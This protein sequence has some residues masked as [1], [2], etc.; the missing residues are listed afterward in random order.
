MA[1][2][3]ANIGVSIDTS[4]ALSQLKNL[5]RQIS[6][7]HTSV[8]K[9]SAT[10]A[11]AQK[12]LQ[13]NFVNSINSIGAFS[14][15]LR[16]VRS[17]TETFT[18][19]LE[20]NKFSMGEYFRFSA[21][22]TKTFGRKFATEMGIIE[23]TAVERVKTL[24]TQYVKL[25]RDASGAMQSI[26]IR[27]N[28]L[29]LQDLGTQAQIAAQKQ[30][31]FN[32]LVKQGSTN[33]LNFG[34][35]TQWAGRQL[36]VGFTLP[37]ITL[38]TVA[39]KTFMDME[40]Q[41][42]KFR[43]VYGDLFTPDAER[44]KA[45][46]EIQDL[47][48]AFTQYGVAASDVVGVA[49]DAA[50]AGFAGVDLQ[51]QTEQSIRLSILG[52]VDYQKALETT[53]SL[54]NAFQL[55]SDDLA[56][57]INF[58]NAVE[59]QTVV[60]LDDITT[61]IPKVAPVIQSLGG[62][63][64]DL[65]FFLAAMKEGGVNA[66]EGANA[67]KS[68]LASLINPTEKSAE[69]LSKMGINIRAIVD[70]NQGDLRGT[71]IGFATALDQLDPL[72]RARAIEQLFG[73]FQFAR[74]STLFDNVIREGNQASRVIDLATASVEELAGMAESELGMSAQSAMN[75]FLKVVEDLKVALVPIGE[76]FLQTVT[77][78]VEVIGDIVAKFNDLPNDVKKA[79]TLVVTLV[80]GL[81]PVVL[82]TFG[83]LANGIANSIKFLALLRNGFLRLTGQTQILGNSTEYMT[84]EQLEAAAAAM[85]LDQAHAKLTQRFTAEASAVMKL[86]DAY[87]AALRSSIK[88]A[89]AN[90]RAMMPGF[91]APQGFA[92]GGM[93]GGSGNKDT[94]PAMLTPGEFVV[95]K[96][97]ASVAMP[98]LK[99]L[100]EGKLPGFNE[101][102][103][104]GRK[105]SVGGRGF[106]AASTASA[107]A[108]QAFAER[109]ISA[110]NKVDRVIDLLDMAQS[111]M[112]KITSKQVQELARKE[113]LSSRQKPSGIQ[114]MHLQEDLGILPSGERVMGSLVRGGTI[115]QNQQLRSGQSTEAFE[116][117]WNKVKD[118]LVATLRDGGLDITQEVKEMAQ[119]IDDEIRD[120]AIKI[121]KAS[122]RGLVDDKILAQAAK[123]VIDKNAAAGGTRGA[124]AG[125][126]LQQ[127][128]QRVIAPA[129]KS[130]LVAS[131]QLQEDQ[132][133]TDWVKRNVAAGLAVLKKGTGE[134]QKEIDGKMRTIAR[135]Q[136]EETRQLLSEMNELEA[137]TALV[138]GKI[139]DERIRLT[140]GERR[141]DSP[142]AYVKSS[143]K[144]SRL[145]G[146][147]A[148]KAFNDGAK[149]ELKKAD[150]AYVEKRKRK[151]PHP[152]AAKDGIDDAKSYDKA[153]E[154]QI[155]QT[156]SKPR[157]ASSGGVVKFDEKSG[158]YMK[159][160]KF[161]KQEA[162]REEARARIAR[163]NGAAFEDLLGKT[164]K[165]SFGLSAAAGALSMFG[166]P[167]GEAAGIMFQLSSALFGL[168]TVTE[169]LSRTKLAAARAE[170]VRTKMGV[171]SGASLFTGGKGIGGLF[172]NIGTGLKFALRFLGPVGIGLSALAVGIPFIVNIMNEQ[173]A[174]IEGL[175][176]AARFTSSQLEFLAER[177]GVELNR[178]SLE[179]AF[180]PSAEGAT[181]S[182]VNEAAKFS[183]DENFL[184][185]FKVPIE[186]IQNVSNE[187]AKTLLEALNIQ[188]QAAGFGPE[189]VQTIL[190]GIAE[191]ANKTDIN[192]E[193]TKVKIDF[194]T[195]EGMSSIR[196]SAQAAMDN[197]ISALSSGEGTPEAFANLSTTFASLFE[198][199]NL[200]LTSGQ[201][202][203]AD[204]NEQMSFLMSILERVGGSGVTEKLAEALNISE[205]LEGVKSYKD[206]LLLIEAAVAGVPDL[207][208][209]TEAFNIL[210]DNDAS[211]E[212]RKQ[213]L[214]DVEDLKI[215]VK[216]AALETQNLT[217]ANEKDAQQI[218][219]NTELQN[220]LNA[221]REGIAKNVEDINNAIA[222]FDILMEAGWSAE[223][224]YSAASNG[225]LAFSI[226][227]SAVDAA[228][229]GI[230]LEQAIA[231]AQEFIKA[232][233]AFED[234]NPSRSG[235]GGGSA[236]KS[237]FQEAIESLKEQ[238]KEIQ[239]TNTA[240][241]KLR[242]TGFSVAAAFAAAKDPIL[243]AAIASTQVGTAKWRELVNLIRQVNS[244][245]IQS[246]D[247]Q[248]AAF[249]D[250]KDR[251]GEY[252]SILRSEVNL[253]YDRT[254]QSQT[255]SI[256]GL[257]S[258]IEAVN[259][260]IAAYQDQISDIQRS[261]EIEFGRPIAAL[262]EESS[263]LSNDLTLIDKAAEEITKRYE[264]QSEALE[265]VRKVNERILN[266][267]KQ[268]QG[269]AAALS[270]GDV[271][272]AA[273]MIQDMRA[274]NA[275][276]AA[277]SQSDMLNAARD[278]ELG[279]LRS[280]SGMTREQILER[281][282]DIGQQIFELEEKKEEKLKAI[283]GLE[284]KI[285]DIQRNRLR[286][287]QAA[288]D[289]ANA[290]LAA[291]EQQRDTEL[292]AI[293]EKERA[294]EEAQ[295][296]L[297]LARIESGEFNDI[298]EMTNGLLEL[299]VGE[300]EDFA[301]YWQALRDKTITL[302][303]RTV[304]ESV[305]GAGTG[306]TGG[307]SDSS[308][309]SSSSS[310]T[311][312]TP[313]PV[314]PPVG[315]PGTGG[316][317]GGGGGGPALRF[318]AS[319]GMVKKYA[320]GGVASS[321]GSDTVPSML[322]PGE[323]V[324][325]RS[326]SRRFGPLLDAI[327]SSRGGMF[328]SL[329]DKARSASRNGFA[330]KS[331]NQS[332]YKLPE[333]SYP[334]PQNA[335][336]IYSSS[337]R[338]QGETGPAQIDNSVY[339]Y[340]L[341]VNVDGGNL[342]A[343]QVANEVINK[344]KRVDSQRLRN[345]VIR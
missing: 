226:A 278:A 169:L 129:T 167:V 89:A 231:D 86:R 298:I 329:G 35:N 306:G 176:N 288:L 157:R 318:M 241:A 252:F 161:L 5:Q 188:L 9:S 49:A 303:V 120:A 212:A 284:D 94:V 253:R 233:K 285:Y 219:A 136:G 336:P 283:Q 239:N 15:E 3:N 57:S 133:W 294:W 322:T 44:Q 179:S 221:A 171:A 324:I 111:N 315:T 262:Q 121:A 65:A 225:A 55:S 108:I 61:A 202:S 310:Q 308:S 345:Q 87:E 141:P 160:D 264:E 195:P 254:I 123:G 96:E 82:M 128:Q 70:T 266:Q 229:A 186:S 97:S 245:S 205:E 24:Q 313:T 282:F 213:A 74:I 1:D 115:T 204:F 217:A 145:E 274:A 109:L 180:T 263:D 208:K 132:T 332:V 198:A 246:F 243:A 331:F 47:A 172:K 343:N 340:N 88:F 224:A 13:T 300:I 203:A 105:V 18:N 31:I 256:N 90:P 62:D 52:Q 327:N 227:L 51:R 191:A 6:Q 71:V 325:N 199:L 267:Q 255:A 319:G 235:G 150:D 81:G 156:R 140:I 106:D 289:T 183:E 328:G 151:S 119:E 175:G 40:T 69:M 287:L 277:V 251:A 2:V 286:P 117:E 295:L 43:K 268:Q 265:Q 234:L 78:F 39:T 222:A 27:P 210:A 194:G 317:G 127:S 102:G 206:Q 177:F 135:V 292:A 28:I 269:L 326:S 20:K 66:S 34:K 273:S 168:V 247:G 197:V 164:Q 341:S 158:Q 290:A 192:L 258:S 67:L 10:A 17:T 182:Q 311:E 181:Q 21:A 301:A 33:L 45:L 72:N 25:G 280:A 134:I 193:F 85:S 41:V 190:M 113:G 211:Q 259:K 48:Q 146:E 73:K 11:A 291:T 83:L 144:D 185:Q 149:K 344:L 126:L 165:L 334:A 249:S 320:S 112:D 237:P 242:D 260:E 138:S 46:E 236:T 248:R 139:G 276:A 26:A 8:A 104:V 60:S 214:E 244:M 84:N 93:V 16:T 64:K 304:T 50:A 19:S 142:R 137:R 116:S 271:S 42:I 163:I 32:Q 335:G 216:S 118:G 200:G 174:K 101:G 201:I 124:V 125:T 76:V 154:Q 296:A 92:S 153:F 337:I 100:N 122:E 275:Q 7:F 333:R 75:R 130:S 170:A 279:G 339:N 38:G 272:A 95:N 107:R 36:M 307:S 342:D 178:P 316:G 215:K 159:E 218:A 162:A 173:K 196:A 131:G 184:A 152:Q 22:S 37:L 220:E 293:A 103:V 209:Y 312:P 80:G 270:S 314:N 238:R 250:L 143:D 110:G 232:T 321:L 4:D 302:T 257:Q 228:A 330:P 166:G 207:S 147:K 155:E 189:Q 30:A 223:D 79:I 63:V 114:R 23:K 187:T 29:D 240:Y 56:E 299:S 305:G 338:G 261:A 309:S 54:Q 148:A 230:S 59:N 297:D 58:L 98:F 281:Q 53:I 68:G 99:A 91:K 77:P 12:A 323:F 14:A